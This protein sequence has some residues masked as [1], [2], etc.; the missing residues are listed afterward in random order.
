M[1]F[2]VCIFLLFVTLVLIIPSAGKTNNTANE[3]QPDYEDVLSAAEEVPPP[4]KNEISANTSAEYYSPVWEVVRHNDYDSEFRIYNQSTNKVERVNYKD[5]VRGAI[6]AEMS[7]EFH[8]EALEAQGI[9]ALTYALYNQK[10]HRDK[11]IPALHG[12][13]FAADPLNWKG[14][15]TKEIAK[16]RYGEKFDVYWSK[17]CSAADEASQ[18]I[19]V[20]DDEPILAAYHSTSG[21]ITEAAENV[22]NHSLPYLIP[23]SSRGDLL[24]PGYE[25]ELT[26][27]A[28]QF[29][30][31]AVNSIAD[32]TFSSEPN[33]WIEVLDRSEGGYA[34]AV[35]VGNQIIHGKKLRSMLEL[36]SSNFS[37]RCDG[38]TFY[39]TVCG[40]GH[41]VG[42]S[43]YG[44][45]FMAM[46]GSNSDE[47][48]CYYFTGAK[49]ASA[50]EYIK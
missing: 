2:N 25:T 32:L 5:Y 40:Y 4:S 20:Y 34:T 50:D 38:K 31:I 29:K 30:E 27:S 41:G 44:A 12:A 15:V 49:I 21:G 18:K 16:E 13:D 45:D 14:F 42:L 36:R 1:K 22:W 47:I 23:V 3:I 43:Q 35:R 11:D 8:S 9:A 28:E 37:V 46:Q 17:I 10:M 7:P 6:C 26:L 48:L 19:I 33:D 24:A 39:F